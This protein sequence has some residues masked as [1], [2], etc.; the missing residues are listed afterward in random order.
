MEGSPQNLGLDACRWSVFLC[1]RCDNV[2]PL[3]YLFLSERIMVFVFAE[4]EMVETNRAQW[5]LFK[6][7]RSEFYIE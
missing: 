4:T 1:L 6:R 5:K 3:S 7:K 2:Q